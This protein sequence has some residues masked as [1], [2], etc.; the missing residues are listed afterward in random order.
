MTTFA[1]AFPSKINELREKSGS[2]P[3]LNRRKMDPD[4][5]KRGPD[6]L[7]RFA[8]RRRLPRLAAICAARLWRYKRARDGAAH[9]RAGRG[10]FR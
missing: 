8:R 1:P 3:G 2:D 4:R 7:T 6:L 9:F 5:N 10:R